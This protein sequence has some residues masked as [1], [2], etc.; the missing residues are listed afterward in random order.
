MLDAMFGLAALHASKQPPTQWIPLDGRMVPVRDS[1]FKAENATASLAPHENGAEIANAV[2]NDNHA[3]YF[4]AQRSRELLLHARKYFDR[5]I[6]GHRCGIGALTKDN[7]EATYIASILISFQ[8]LFS[9]S[10]SDEDGLLPAVDAIVWLRLADGTRYLCDI[11]RQIAGDAWLDDAGVYFGRPKLQSAEELYQREEGRPFQ[12]LLTF[13]E[14]YE[15]ISPEDK[16]VYQQAV[17]ALAHIY[18]SITEDID[19]PLVNCRRL[20]AMPSQLA[21][22]FTEMIEMRNPRAMMILAYTF[23]TMKIL[24][25]KVPWFRGIA[26]RQIPGIAAGVPPAWNEMTKWPLEIAE[27]RDEPRTQEQD[28]RE[29]LALDS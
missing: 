7:V 6:E 21:R 8:A 1:V 10:E 3:D 5:A 23:A 24:A 4:G 27:N 25:E 13:A 19:P 16:A 14:E 15:T 18:K 17:A 9:L 29:A 20:V 11:W 28:I 12:A 22:R 2:R 26:E